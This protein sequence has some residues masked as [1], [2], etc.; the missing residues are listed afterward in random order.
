MARWLGVRGDDDAQ[1]RNDMDAALA[2]AALD[3][4]NAAIVEAQDGGDPIPQD[5]VDLLQR[6]AQ[7][8]LDRLRSTEDSSV[9]REMA[10]RRTFE[11]ARAMVQAEQEELLRLRDEQ[12][13]PDALVR[14]K[15]RDLDM[16]TQALGTGE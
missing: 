15:L 16:R 12:G 3:R 14:L 7:N 9:T 2:K 8:R 1:L 6:D 5:V 4:L 13:F 10:T 11:L